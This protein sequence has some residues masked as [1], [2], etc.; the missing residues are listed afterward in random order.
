M[1]AKMRKVTTERVVDSLGGIGSAFAGAMA[2]RLVAEQLGGVLKNSKTKH[3][4]L[5]L[6]SAIG[7]AMLNR[8]DNTQALIQDA[9]Y[10]FSSTQLN[11]FVKEF[12]KDKETHEV[13]EG[14]VK[15]ALGT[16]IYMQDYYEPEIEEY[17][18]P[19]EEPYYEPLQE[20][21]IEF[22]A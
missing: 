20:R 6:V 10:G 13:K 22:R 17:Y 8:R 5:T 3:G 11:A 4:I 7:I 18:Y 2:S 21:V 19:Y 15:T 12:V 9:L 1:S 14:M 16:P